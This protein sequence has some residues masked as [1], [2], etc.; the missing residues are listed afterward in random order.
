MDKI[1]EAT[2]PFDEKVFDTNAFMMTE[3]KFGLDFV[4]QQS[5]Q[6]ALPGEHVPD[7]ARL[8]LQTLL[9][10]SVKM[11]TKEEY[12]GSCIA[13][14]FYPIDL[15]PIDDDMLLFLVDENTSMSTGSVETHWAWAE[16]NEGGILV[17]YLEEGMGATC[18]GLI[19]S[20]T[21]LAYSVM[22]LL[23]CNGVVQAVMVSGKGGLGI[24]GLRD[25][26]D[27]SRDLFAVEKTG[28]N[29]VGTS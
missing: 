9:G 27:L 29:E 8:G 22:F 13:M 15:D 17:T 5:G 12:K 23:D 1:E 24:G 6:T 21:H 26:L 3:I 16:A 14:A 19:V 28:D 4:Y 2:K 11:E 10:E 20:I 25:I 18:Y 7:F